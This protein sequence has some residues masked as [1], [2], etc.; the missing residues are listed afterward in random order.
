[1][2]RGKFYIIN[3]QC[4]LFST[5][6]NWLVVVSGPV[7]EKLF[8]DRLVKND[9]EETIIKMLL[10]LRFPPSCPL[11]A[12]DNC[13]SLSVIFFRNRPFPL[14][15]SKLHYHCYY[16]LLLLGHYCYCYY[17]HY[18]SHCIPIIWRWWHWSFSN[19]IDN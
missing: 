5:F 2:G 6:I 9:N 4:L 18:L 16:P 3:F 19:F 7:N 13:N 12:D 15:Q 10:F 14:Y 8:D 1:M 17:Y 11:K